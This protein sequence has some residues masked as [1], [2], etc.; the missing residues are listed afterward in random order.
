MNQVPLLLA[1]VLLVATVRLDPTGTHLVPVLLGMAVAQGAI[2]LVAAAEL[3]NAKWIAPVRR[4]LLG[5]TPLLFVFPLLVKLAP[6]PWLQHETA[7]LRADFFLARNSAALALFAVIAHLYR[8]RTL[9]GKP[10]SRQWAVAVIFAFVVT[11]TLVAMD[12]TMSLD[13]PWISTM[14]P[15]LYMV[16]S[17]A[18]GLALLGLLCFAR[19]QADGVL[20]DTAT[21]MFGFALF[22]GGLFFAQYLTIW[23]ANIPEEVGYFTGRFARPG[24]R[25]FFAGTVVLLFAVPFATLLIHRARKSLPA[26]FFLA[27]VVLLGI[28]LHR[29]FHVLPHVPLHL[30]WLALQT[31]AMAGA[32]AA[33][34]R[35]DGNSPS[36]VA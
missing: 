26:V 32:I 15:V 18:A 2:V 11:Q 8:R 31:A 4:T 7:W 34:Q 29:V 23:Y 33:S 5:V 16:E 19:R 9:A 17:F 1:A 21:L 27:H 24:G 22:W 13:Y 20:Y 6:Y 30:G 25:P 35:A 12:W 3:A 10:T 14:F 28:L 36:N